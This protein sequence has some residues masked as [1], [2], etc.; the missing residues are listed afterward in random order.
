LA[1]LGAFSVLLS[2]TRYYY[3]R[4]LLMLEGKLVLMFT[5]VRGVNRSA[6]QVLAPSLGEAREREG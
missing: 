3:S 4:S 5:D 1:A 2:G 6:T